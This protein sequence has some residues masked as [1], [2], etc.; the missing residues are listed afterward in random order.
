MFCVAAA[1][2]GCGDGRVVERPGDGDDAGGDVVAGADLFELVG[3]GE[4]A[5]EQRLLV[6]LRVAAEV[7]C[8]EGGD[9]LF[10]HGSG[11]QAGVHGGVVDDAD[12]VLLAEGEIFGFVGAVEHGVGRLLRGD[13]GDLHDALHLRDAEVGDA[14]PADFSFALEV[15]HGGPALFDVFV[16]LGP[17]DL[18][19][20]DGFDL[21][22][23]EAGFALAADLFLGVGDFFFVVPDH[24]GLG[25]DVGFVRGGLDGFGYD[26]F[27][28]A[29]AVDGGGVDPV[30]AEVEGFV[31]GGD[32]VV[33]VLRAPCEGPVA[34]ANGPCA[35]ADGGEVEV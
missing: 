32:G 16:G 10:G 24:G 7:V 9:A 15:G 4:V 21:Q 13:G 11:E 28:V 30:D 5:G 20:V 23:A 34:S 33:V 29:E 17:V 35:E 3:Y 14:D 1:D 22:A 6:V 2:D 31:D 12:V 25:E 26:F 18:V 8:G 27:G 19:E